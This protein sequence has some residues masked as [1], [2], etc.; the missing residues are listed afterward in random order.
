MNVR[1]DPTWKAELAQEWE[2]PYF[3][4]LTEYVRGE[5]RNPAVTVYPPAAK[6]F[7]AFDE[8]PFDKVKVVILGQDPYHGPGQANGLCFSVGPGVQLPPSLVN[9]FKEVHRN[10]RF[11]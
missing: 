3:E 1:I 2:K 9:I 4:E 8:C 10:D 7:S 11:K 5:Y 6:I